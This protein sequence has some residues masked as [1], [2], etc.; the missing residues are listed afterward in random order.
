MKAG[1]QMQRNPSETTTTVPARARC[2]HKPHACY[3]ELGPLASGVKQQCRVPRA[4]LPNT[5]PE[6][7]CVLLGPEGS[8]ALTKRYQQ[9]SVCTVLQNHRALKNPPFGV[10]TLGAPSR[11]VHVPEVVASLGTPNGYMFLGVLTCY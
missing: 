3:T 2:R 8:P 6:Q 4:L 9:I 11:S 5:P 10:S 1:S 7:Q